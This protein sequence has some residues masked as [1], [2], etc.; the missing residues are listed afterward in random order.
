MSQLS[1]IVDA[2]GGLRPFA[3][4]L[5][6]PPSTVQ[7][8]IEKGGIPASAVSPIMKLSEEKGLGLSRDQ[9]SAAVPNGLRSDQNIPDDEDFHHAI[10]SIEEIHGKVL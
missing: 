6:K 7:Y 2:F 8:W 9:V 1:Q 10:S 4:V 5:N 3:R